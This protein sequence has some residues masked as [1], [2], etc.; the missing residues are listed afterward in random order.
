MTDAEKVVDKTAPQKVVYDH[1]RKEQHVDRPEGR[2]GNCHCT[3][4][5]WT[6]RKR[7]ATVQ[8]TWYEEQSKPE[9]RQKSCSSSSDDDEEKDVASAM[10]DRSSKEEQNFTTSAEDDRLS[11]DERNNDK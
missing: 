11:D 8:F 4:V 7:R 5:H 9:E 1:G 6:G 2:H 3:E 10:D